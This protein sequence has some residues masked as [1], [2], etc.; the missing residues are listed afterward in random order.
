MDALCEHIV[1][2]EFMT[3]VEH[4]IWNYYTR[5][6]QLYLPLQNVF[7][8]IILSIHYY[9]ECHLQQFKTVI[10]CGF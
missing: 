9:R 4:D 6:A 10:S 1:L 3:V 7:V 2:L 8:G 5:I